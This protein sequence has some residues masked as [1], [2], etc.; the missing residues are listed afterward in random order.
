MINIIAAI[1]ILI[2]MGTTTTEYDIPSSYE[3]GTMS[4]GHGNVCREWYIL[5]GEEIYSWQDGYLYIKDKCYGD[6]IVR[7]DDWFYYEPSKKLGAYIDYDSLENYGPEVAFRTFIYKNF[8]REGKPVELEYA[9]FIIDVKPSEKRSE[10]IRFTCDSVNE[11]N[12]SIAALDEMGLI[13]DILYVDVY[14]GTYEP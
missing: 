10:L 3:Y 14:F 6:N 12:E 8:C 1:M 9:R 13:D 7:T 4:D 11:Y 2:T 5:E